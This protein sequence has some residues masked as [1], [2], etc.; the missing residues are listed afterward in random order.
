MHLNRHVEDEDYLEVVDSA[1]FTEFG[2]TF[3]ATPGPKSGIEKRTFYNL[4]D[5]EIKLRAEQVKIIHK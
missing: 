2:K 1:S 4:T 3:L 5:E